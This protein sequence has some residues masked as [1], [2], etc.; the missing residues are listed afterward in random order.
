[1]KKNNVS[2]SLT[3]PVQAG[4]EK[5]SLELIEKWGADAIR[6]SSSAKLP[7]EMKSGSY[8]IYSQIC[9]VRDDQKWIRENWD[10]LPQ[11]FLMSE[12]VTAVSDEVTI[13]PIENYFDK[14]YEID[15]NH[16]P[17]DWW[18]VFDRTT[19]EEVPKSDW[20][21]DNNNKTVIITKV[22]KFH[23]YT[24]NFLVYQ[25]WDSTSMYDHLINNWTIPPIVS[26]EPYHKDAYEHL[27]EYFDNWLDNHKY[28]SVIRLTTLCYHFVLDSDKNG[29]DKYRDWMGYMDTISIEALLDFE[30][31]YGYRLT[32]EDF[33][34]EGY[35]NAT[36]RIPNKK[37]QDWMEF[38]Q[39]FVSEFGK[40]LVDKVHA[41]GKKAAIFQ[42]DHWI[43]VEP[44]S[45]T[46]KKIGIDINVG[47]AEDGV[48]LRR[49]SDSDCDEIKE[50]RLYPYFFP[51]VFKPGGNPTAESL[52]NWIKIRR[53][54]LRKPI[55]RT[56]Y[57]GRLEL[58]HQFPDFVEHVTKLADEFRSIK[59]NSQM[60][61]PYSLPIKVAVLNSWG[62]IRSWMN[63]F[64]RDQKFFVKRPDV[65]AVAGSNLLECLS[66]LQ[67]EI[68]F[69]SFDDIKETGIPE[70][71]NVIINEGEMN[72]SWSGGKHWNDTALLTKIKEWIY[73]G[74]GFIGNIEP[75]A[76]PK[77]GRVFQLADIMGVD[78]ELGSS[79]M[80]AGIPFELENNHFIIDDNFTSFDFFNEK[81]YVFSNCETTKVLKTNKNGLHI[82]LAANEFGNGRSV[83]FAGLPYSLENTRLLLRAIIWAANK[84]EN[85]KT[86][87]SFNL[88]TECAAYPEVK[89]Y[90]VVN[91]T[92]EIQ[93][94]DIY[95]SKGERQTIKLKSYESRWF[96]IE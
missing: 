37:Y 18:Q 34:D 51:D 95:N 50:I 53:A 75:T 25:I 91:N 59:E 10:K 14:K 17:K 42:G 64:G 57:G 92:A 81:S 68:M 73:N 74:G 45:E 40:E 46:Y 2:G 93:T 32:S 79:V 90:V 20:Y 89:K 1:M 43:G 61:K 52:S 21:F 33:V 30:K 6:D 8:D 12:F 36:H 84:E 72:S 41:Q 31:E 35:Y 29:V 96:N 69:L 27:M 7:E 77:N 16:N 11:K 63:N 71:V 3:L 9:L 13:N 38:I 26:T 67:V 48:A 60:T 4:K 70:D 5:E 19:G 78:K 86:W 62:K 88:N 83:Y 23:V 76:F 85:Y 94:T 56:G 49:L 55:D 39:K 65:I 82:Q 66:G 80:T 44:Y 87:F 54:I 24:V 22:K 28:S 15:L 58:A 47:A